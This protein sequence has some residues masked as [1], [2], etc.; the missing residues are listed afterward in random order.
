MTSSSTRIQ[1]SASTKISTPFSSSLI[2]SPV[3][4]PGSKSDTFYITED[5]LLRTQTS[6]HQ[7]E[8]IRKSD[9]F[10]VFADVYRRDQIDATHYPVF[11]QIEMVRLYEYGQI[12]AY[13]EA[14]GHKESLKFS[15][16]L[17][18]SILQNREYRYNSELPFEEE[19]RLLAVI[20]EDIKQTH[21]NLVHF[22]LNDPTVQTRWIDGYFP[23][24]EPSL[25][26]EAFFNEKWVEML[27]CG[28]LKRGHP[29]T[30]AGHG[31][32]AVH[33]VHGVGVRTRHRAT[34]DA[35]VRDSGYQTVL[36]EG[37][38]VPVSVRKRENPKVP[39][40]Q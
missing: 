18:E 1:S 37:P 31:R 30:G 32:E 26:L 25:E 10:C 29:Q 24:T 3:P 27:G 39:A 19:V 40:V 15:Q 9:A 11:H 6:A 34:G 33:A 23:F 5:T 14:N 8:N 38:P 16:K 2:T 7:N 21:E 13:L 36:V 22:I 35:V 28:S 12:R 20:V 17:V 4:S